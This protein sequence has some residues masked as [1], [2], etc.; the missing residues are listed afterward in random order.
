MN[1]FTLSHLAIFISI[2]GLL[3]S[4]INVNRQ[5]KASYLNETEKFKR[6]T[7]LKTNDEFIELL[8]Q[9]LENTKLIRTINIPFDER[10]I[11]TDYEH[12]IKE[13]NEKFWLITQAWLKCLN[14][15]D[16]FYLKRI[17]IIKQYNE[18]YNLLRRN[19]IELDRV[20]WITKNKCLD[21]EDLDEIRHEIN[22]L[23]PIS[24]EYINLIEECILKVQ[25]DFLG[26][27]FE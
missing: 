27:L 24:E 16:T 15:L 22:Q 14:S 21:T 11:N 17:V 4:F 9:I 13:F 25:K 1:N 19:G 8:F 10:Y 26:K 23:Q 18:L 6:D 12:R 7:R 20:L 3:I 2:S 5:R